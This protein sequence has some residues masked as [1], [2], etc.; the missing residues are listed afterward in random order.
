MHSS[1]SPHGQQ[2]MFNLANVHTLWLPFDRGSSLLADGD[3]K[4]CKVLKLVSKGE[5]PAA[6]GF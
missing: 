4:A 5:A 2:E 3:E 6:T 1:A